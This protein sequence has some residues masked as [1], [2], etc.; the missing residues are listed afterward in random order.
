[1]AK[2]NEFIGTKRKELFVIY[3]VE[4]F[5][6]FDIEYDVRKT[7]SLV[8]P[9]TGHI[10][11]VMDIKN[12]KRCGDIEFSG[13]YPKGYS[14]IDMALAN[15][16]TETCFELSPYQRR[17]RFEFAYQN[18][19]WILKSIRFL[20][21]GEFLNNDFLMAVFGMKECE[22]YLFMKEPAGISYNKRI[23]GFINKYRE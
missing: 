13:K 8:S 5:I 18:N 21:R 19:K 2:N 4:Q 12:N 3:F 15:D 14:N 9:Y 16:T 23:Y 17:E 7:D 10:D 1:V 6:F 20:V 22:Y 11:I